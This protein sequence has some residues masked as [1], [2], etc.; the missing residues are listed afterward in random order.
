MNGKEKILELCNSRL[1]VSPEQALYVLSVPAPL[2]PDV[3][4]LANRVRLDNCGPRIHLCSIVNAKSGACPEDCA[5]CAQ[6]ARHN[7]PADV[8][9]MKSG[10]SIL[11]AYGK[12]LELPVD[13][14]GVVTSGASAS[15]NDLSVLEQ[16]IQK[17]QGRHVAWCGSLGSL[18]EN[19]LKR[20]KKAGMKRFHH[21]LE[22]AESF[23]PNVCTTHTYSDRIK[24][25]RAA[26]RA[27]M[28]LCCGGILGMGESLEQ[29]VEFAMTLQAEKVDSIPLNFLMPV[30]GTRFEKLKPMRPLDILRCIAMFRLTNPKAE[31]KVCA[32]RTHL[33][34]LQSMI[35]YAGATGMMI[36]DLLTIAG[37]DVAAD[38]QMLKDLEVD[39]AGNKLD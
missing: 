8:Y 18:G 2:M 28:E 23:F 20:L 35:F 4:A 25:L 7:T 14:F 1:P 32:G 37:R 29:R 17:E 19:Q 38:L 24:T 6:S 27:G 11:H 39:D 16:V 5:F 31:I 10:E 30:D 26:R 9:P 22:T 33:R 13:H 36:G 15:E 12:A 21:N 3:F 34:D